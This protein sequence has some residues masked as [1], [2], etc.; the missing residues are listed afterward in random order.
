MSP[1]QNNDSPQSL[2][3]SVPP[4]GG[5]KIAA[6]LDSVQAP[7]IGEDGRLTLL[8]Q[9]DTMFRSMAGNSSSASA[10]IPQET[11]RLLPSITR[12]LIQFVGELQ[13][14]NSQLHMSYARLQAAQENLQARERH[15]EA[16]ISSLQRENESLKDTKMKLEFQYHDI[17]R[18]IGEVERSYANI[19][20]Q[21]DILK[22][23]LDRIKLGA[24]S[25][26]D[27]QGSSKKRSRQE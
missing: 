26:S 4:G 27:M 19:K 9:I 23:E 1:S 21:K 10:S 20:A 6:D 11:L 24:T 18:D 7:Y 22:A 13:A 16:R 14:N 12:T 25:D 8:R 15:T 17:K 3:E 5:F 2:G